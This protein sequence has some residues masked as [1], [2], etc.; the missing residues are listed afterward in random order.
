MQ[1]SFVFIFF[2]F[3]FPLL[4]MNFEHG[5]MLMLILKSATIIFPCHNFLA[6]IVYIQFN[7]YTLLGATK[8][9]AMT[10]TRQPILWV[11]TPHQLCNKVNKSLQSWACDFFR[12]TFVWNNLDIGFS[13]FF[14]RFFFLIFQQNVARIDE[15]W[16]QT[17]SVCV[18]VVKWNEF[19]IFL[20]FDR[21][22][23]HLGT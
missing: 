22:A 6:F 14:F 19:L 15:N 12:R 10:H 17:W 18:C 20:I 9:C 7:V 21:N 13:F 2:S 1:Y 23:V 11:E 5:D 4:W 16:C 3:F 8:T